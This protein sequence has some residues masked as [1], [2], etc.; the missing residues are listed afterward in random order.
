MTFHS[1]LIAGLDPAIQKVAQHSAHVS[2]DARVKP[3]H[4]GLYVGAAGAREHA[5]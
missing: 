4:E 2:M 3:G 5:R 1:S